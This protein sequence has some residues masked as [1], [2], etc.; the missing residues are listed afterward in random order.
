MPASVA[1]APP[2]IPRLKRSLPRER[3]SMRTQT[4]LVES[5][6]AALPVSVEF[7]PKMKKI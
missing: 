3:E 6:S 2:R 4:G 7:S 5:R 1:S